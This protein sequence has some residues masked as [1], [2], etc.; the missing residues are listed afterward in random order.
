M[1]RKHHSKRLHIVALFAVVLFSISLMSSC[2]VPV[3]LYIDTGEL[4]ITGDTS[5]DKDLITFT[6]ELTDDALAEFNDKNATP[7]IKL[8]YVISNNILP[9]S[10]IGTPENTSMTVKSRTI[11]GFSS[12]YAK[13]GGNGVMWTPKSDTEAPA[14]YIY[15]TSDS[16]IQYSISKPDYED[17]T[18]Y[19]VIPVSTFSYCDPATDPATFAKEPDMDIALTSFT[20][21]TSSTW[22]S[23]DFTIEL[24][25]NTG[26]YVELGLYDSTNTLVGYMNNYKT[27][28]FYGAGADYTDIIS[29][30]EGYDSVS[31]EDFTDPINSTNSNVYLHIFA[32]LYGGNGDTTNIFWSP[33]E[34]NAIGTIQLR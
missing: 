18:S 15:D 26:Q 12:L 11:S 28:R 19:D 33:I 32:A 31:Y 9:G 6:L 34:T 27:D 4:E 2:G 14:F 25:D 23:E 7:S 20:A 10:T 30:Y 13:S 8:F 3:Y 17:G 24:I 29:R 1:Y 16:S 5:D 22:N 21:D